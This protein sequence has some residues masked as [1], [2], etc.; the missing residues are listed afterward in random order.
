MQL[1]DT[2]TTIGKIICCIRYK[3][4]INVKIVWVKIIEILMKDI[5][6]NHEISLIFH[7]YRD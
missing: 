7:D 5:Y 4:S 3:K 6:N 2:I 1:W